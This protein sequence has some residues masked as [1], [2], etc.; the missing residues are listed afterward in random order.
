MLTFGEQEDVALWKVSG[1]F[2]DHFILELGTRLAELVS[3]QIEAENVKNF[4]NSQ[5]KGGTGIQVYWAWTES[6]LVIS[7][8][9]ELGFIRIYMA[10]CKSIV[11]GIVSNFL[12]NQVGEILQFRYAEI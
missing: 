7:T 12:K 4:P 11:P 5:G 10:S 3:M 8:W 9:P 6:F 2:D 1:V